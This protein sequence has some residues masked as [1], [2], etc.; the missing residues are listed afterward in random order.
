VR[1]VLVEPLAVKGVLIKCSIQC[2]LAQLGRRT[3]RTVDTASE[4]NLLTNPPETCGECVCV[5]VPYT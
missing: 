5:C 2:T 3:P 1:S 4:S